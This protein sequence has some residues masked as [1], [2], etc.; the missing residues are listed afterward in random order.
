MGFSRQEYWNGLLFP[1]PGDLPNP[2]I[3]PRSP[4][5]QA[6][7]LSSEPPGNLLSEPPGNLHL[8]TGNTFR[9][10][11]MERFDGVVGLIHWEQPFLQ[12]LQRGTSGGE[13]AKLD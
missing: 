9:A 10:D 1:S 3:K 5:L 8:P 11:F 4:A 6:D 13:L 2:R 7:S 12:K